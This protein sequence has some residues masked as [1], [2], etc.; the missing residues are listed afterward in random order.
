MAAVRDVLFRDDDL[1][2]M[3]L[4]P[5]CWGFGGSLDPAPVLEDVLLNRRTDEEGKGA[6]AA[7]EEEIL[8]R[9][10]GRQC[11]GQSLGDQ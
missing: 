1:T 9:L 7:H 3:D 2:E 5:A 8:V 6:E 4:D 10:H 11:T